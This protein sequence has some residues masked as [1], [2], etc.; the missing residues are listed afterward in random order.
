MRVE[1][2]LRFLFCLI[3]Y[4]LHYN[5]GSKAV[6]TIGVLLQE[7]A[8]QINIPL[9]STIYKK[10]MFDQ[11]AYFS[12]KILKVSPSDNFEASQTLCT[13]LD[14]D[15]GVVAVYSDSSR[16]TPIL[17][18]TCTFFE[19]PFIT[20]SWKA[21][22]PA[23]RNP[24]EVRAMINFFPEAEL[25]AKGLAEIVRSLQW[26]S[27]II[28]YENEEGL[29]RMQEI[30][31]LQEINPDS[32]K[33]N[34]VVM[35]LGP[36]PD[37]RPLLKKIHN[38]TE[39]NII[40]DCEV[41]KILPIL[42]QA[43][44]VGML[45]L[46]NRYFI[47]SLDAHTLDFSNL[48]TTANITTIRLHDPKS[49]DFLNTVHRWELTEFE[50]HNRR[51]PL[52]PYSIKTETVLFHD[53]ILL[54]TDTV[55]AMTIK[56]GINIKP[57]ACNGT[58]TS[59]DGFT[60]RKYMLI[61]TPSMT[62][63]GPLKFNDE[64]GRTDFN[65]HVVDIIDDSV[66][67]TWHAGN[68][69]ME[70]HRNYN[71]TFDAAVSNLQKITVI[72]AS[73]IGEPYLM[74]RQPSYEGEIL[75]GN[76]RYE[77]YSMDLIAGIAKF[78]GFNF[79]FEIT[80]K[81][82]NYDY[83]EK[84]WNGLIGELLEKRAHLAVCDF[85]ITPERREV[86]DFSMPFMTLGIAILHKSQTEKPI[87]MFK[88]LE[89]FSTRVWLY[90][91]TLYL[92]ISIVLFFISR[93]TP[94]DWE[95]PHPCEDDPEELE[96]IWD[97]KNSL[98]LTLGSIMT[99]GCDILP[100]GISS[101]MAVG[102]WWFFS[103]IM[104][105][106]YTANLAAFLTK[107]N[108]EPAIDSAEAL[109]KQTKIKYGLVKGGSTESFFRN[110]N[111]STYQ[112]M[113]LSIQQTKPSVYEDSN[114]DGVLRVQTTKLA[115]Y[116]FLMESTQIEYEIETKCD[117]KQ[118]G[119]KLDSK[120]YGIAMPM[121]SPYRSAINKAVLVMQESGEL[122]DLKTKWWKTKRKEASCDNQKSG[123]EEDANKLGIANLGGVFLV[124]G[125][126][127][128]MACV[129]A[130]IEF[131]WNCRNIS[132]EEHITYKQAF[133]LELKFACNI[134]IT[135]KR[136]KPLL[137]EEGSSQQSDKSAE[138]KNGNKSIINSILHSAGSNLNIVN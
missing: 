114:A 53:A 34:I 63:T 112:R 3:F 40:L 123:E 8:S 130:L 110:S 42:T 54:L 86:V 138:N 12:T 26:P 100:K 133:M 23:K 39:D 31:K 37:Y 59:D 56:P 25:F 128:A 88:F 52:D 57:L 28:I 107:A 127:I 29:I 69:S 122:G 75:T 85:T 104:T 17:E 105:S 94:G 71:Q 121:N 49:D 113:W 119:E 134:L 43:N 44:S 78:I 98:W 106:S 5:E 72:V 89:P 41:D 91:G 97:I 83:K 15:L 4:Q 117:L 38:T 11:R 33:N 135:K 9:N 102:M 7:L 116:A 81:Y 64:G 47:T 109:S 6:V 111:F 36:G 67:A 50:N 51:V 35:Q 124:L 16:T 24:E 65:I 61:N 87:D 62:L 99:Q 120:S 137:S 14:S 131:L 45:G 77:G 21:P 1:T 10:N 108:L 74:L 48:N 95:N 2:C 60:L 68:E 30:L 66:I 103:L 82:G 22:S 115:Q 101:R 118:I 79:Q 136:V 92:V 129:F 125:V 20:T 84:R 46:H 13:L 32:K 73:K 58:E 70:L 80:D 19:V 27:F 55:N 126:G 96:N 18:S 93:L 76:N 90:T 132:V